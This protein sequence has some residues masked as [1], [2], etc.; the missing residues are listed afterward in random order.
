M[1]FVFRE[2]IHKTYKTLTVQSKSCT[3]GRSQIHEC[4]IHHDP[5]DGW[6][7]SPSSPSKAQ[8]R[9]QYA[10]SPQFDLCCAESFTLGPVNIP[11]DSQSTRH[12]L[13]CRLLL[14]YVYSESQ[15]FISAQTWSLER[16]LGSLCSENMLQDPK[17]LLQKEML[18]PKS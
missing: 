9:S 8:H 12:S 3:R 16:C 15:L 14:P 1:G 11:H 5:P 2:N 6:P 17:Q 13:G 10:Q 7:P 18:T 4:S